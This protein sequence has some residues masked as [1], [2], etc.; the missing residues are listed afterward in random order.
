MM[1]LASRT[2]FLRSK[3]PMV[4]FVL[5]YDLDFQGYDLSEIFFGVLSQLLLDKILPHFE[6][7]VVW[8][9]AFQ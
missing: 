1:I 8:V 3:N 9:G 4:L 5:T 6:H 2:M 7:K